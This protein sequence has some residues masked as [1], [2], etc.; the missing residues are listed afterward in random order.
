[1]AGQICGVKVHSPAARAGIKVGEQLLAVN[2]QSVGD[3]IE[4]SFLQAEYEVELT[5]GRVDGSTYNVV[6]EKELDEDLGLEFASAVFDQ[7]R[8]CHNGCIFCFV[9]QMIPGMRKALYVKDDDYRLSF[10]YG[11]FVTLTNMQ[12]EDYQRIISTHMSPLYIS[13]HTTDPQVRC[14]MMRNRFAGDIIAKLQRLI[15]AGIEIHTQI[16]CC[17]GYN[18][19]DVLAQTFQDLSSL[20]PGV[21]SMAVVPVGLTKHR[22][23]LTPL[24]IF[25]PAE[26]AD[27][28]KQAESWQF[29]CRKKFGN[30]FVYLGDEFYLLAKRNIPSGESYD[31]FPQL[32][33]GIGLTRAFL[34]EWQQNFQQ[35]VREYKGE[36]QTDNAEN[37]LLPVGESA[38]KVLTPLLAEFSS[39]T[40]CNCRV[41]SV[42]NKFFGGAVNVTGLL[43]GGDISDAV[44]GGT[45]ILLPAVT[46][47]KDNLFLDD[48]TLAEFCS[49]VGVPVKVVRD[50]RELLHALI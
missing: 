46:L 14:A 3:I 35:A 5:L 12:E 22:E 19:G 36:H 20:Y 42:K 13:V 18:D 37:I 21:R 39:A 23:Q 40:G 32:E 10:L 9:D 7:V 28:C 17:A 16:V 4:L 50:A 33:N 44:T 1:M 25:T 27:I 15:A 30:G 48:M 41:V 11:N 26:A 31:G 47:N 38:A 45:K 29:Q 49:K 43:S 24:R 34:D 8:T 2:G 6:I